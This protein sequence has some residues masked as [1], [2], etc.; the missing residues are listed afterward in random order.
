MAGS[1]EEAVNASV[2]VPPTGQRMGVT[3]MNLDR[4]GDGKLVEHR[5]QVDMLGLMQ[6]IGMVPFRE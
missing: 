3:F 5:A 2:G 4:F 6:Q 1:H